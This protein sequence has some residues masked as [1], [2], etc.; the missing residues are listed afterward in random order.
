MTIDNKVVTKLRPSWLWP[1]HRTDDVY[2][3]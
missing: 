3:R 1:G 2:D